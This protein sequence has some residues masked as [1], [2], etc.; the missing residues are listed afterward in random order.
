MA[1][2]IAAL[3]F[4]NAK[5]DVLI[6]RIYKDD[7]RINVPNA[8]RSQIL[9]TRFSDGGSVAPVRTVGA[10]TFIYLRNSDVY[11][12]GVS[13]SNANAM[14][15]LQFMAQVVQLFKAY[16]GGEFTEAA[17]K[18][19]F[20]LVYELLDEI[21]DYGIPQVAD[22]TILKGFIM[23]KGSFVDMLKKKK[24]DTDAS[25]ATLQVTGAVGWRREGIRHK[26]NEVFLDIIEQVNMLM[27][28]QGNVLRCDVNG[29]VM[30]KCFLSG[31]PDVKVGL[32]D[33]LED[34]TF[35]Q[36]VNLGRF[37]SEK[38]VSFVPPDGEFE[39]MKYRS[40]DGISLPF[41]ITPVIKETGRTRLQIEARLR[42]V[43]DQKLFAMQLVV[44][45][46]VPENTSNAALRI[47]K[48]K[49]KY[50]AKR[51][52]IVW[53]IKRFMGG[54]ERSIQADVELISTTRERKP[55]SKPPIQLQFQVPMFSSSGLRVQYLKVWEKSNYKVDKWVR[56][57]TKSGDYQVRL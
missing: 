39:L 37:N 13:A 55:W 31:M 20:V 34:V 7:V 15:A 40:T 22:P 1:S 42:G 19:N 53:K 24:D 30:M 9:N 5:G 16:F 35:H 26:K 46:P 17:I 18:R 8:F 57:L 32:N 52:A 29:K 21:M 11:V 2:A 23:Q 47:D 10:T 51:N 3:Y 27:S 45:I 36:C 50:D 33:K 43:F 41:K 48:G 38:V 54:D 25:N 14:L 44:I 28:S 49:A 12:L 56:K 6:Q 4:V